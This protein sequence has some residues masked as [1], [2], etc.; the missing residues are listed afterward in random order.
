MPEDPDVPRSSGPS[1]V[2][3][4]PRLRADLLRAN[5]TVDAVLDRIGDLGQAGLGR[6]MTVPADVAL[7]EA[8]DPL[9]ALIRV[10]LLQQCVPVDQLAEAVDVA[11]LTSAGFLS[12]VDG[13]LRA[14]VDIRP[15]GSPDDDAS[16]WVVSDLTP[17][18]DLNMTPTRPDYV[19][20]VS[21][22]STTLAQITMRT[23]VGS[24]LDLG[25]GCGVQ[26]LHLRRHADRVVATDVNARALDLARFTA[27]L[28]RV[29]IELRAGSLY[30]PV[31]GERF[32]LIVSNPPFVMSPPTADAETLTYR[33][34]N[35]EGDRLVET[36][37]RGC[38]DHLTPGGS[39]QLLTNWA[40]LDDAWEERLRGWVPQ[41]CDAWF[42]ERERLDVFAYIEMWLTDA[43]LAGT[44]RWRPAYDEWLAYFDRLGIRA[45]GMGWV[46][47]TRTDRPEPVLRFESWPHQVA[48]PVG[49]VF[50]RNRAAVDASL[51]PIGQL[52]ASRPALVA[53]EQETIG[54]P[55]AEDP[56]HVVFR[57]RVGL[58][59]AV[60]ADTALAAVLG[61]LDGDLT[62]GQVIGAVAQVL[63]LDASDLAASVLPALRDA[64]ADQLL[65]I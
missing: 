36:L 2:T 11:A 20:G 24:A 6:N 46:L 10:F 16:G 19:L 33:E 26:S 62:V 28:N 47:I 35:F 43:G 64:L 34:A 13:G 31:A 45:I 7:G 3:D 51:L 60:K 49:E 32:D 55:G 41:G 50:A 29:D 25:T 65:R 27:E 9:A 15:Y 54:Q 48:Q 37:V 12:H 14:A 8:A 21:P 57:Q 59:R 52:L 40:I 61:A 18:L 42:I 56:E 39:L 30:E 5:Y 23:T 58:L 53:V 44:R 4:A 1:P 38:G 17:G 22:A 63:E